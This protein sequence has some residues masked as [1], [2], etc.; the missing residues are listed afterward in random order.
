MAHFTGAHVGRLDGKGRILV[1]KPFRD[2]LRSMVD[3]EAAS[4]RLRPS[5]ND[6]CIEGWPIPEYDAYSSQALVKIAEDEVATRHFNIIFH[7]PTLELEPD[8]DGRSK[9]PAS[10]IGHA[11]ITGEVLFLGSG[12]KFEIWAKEAA[13]ARLAAAASFRATK[14][15]PLVANGDT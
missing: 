5:E 14:P 2:T 1:P 7:W 15:L 9:L 13:L 12:N 8:G 10:L 4:L 3:P 11:E 6:P